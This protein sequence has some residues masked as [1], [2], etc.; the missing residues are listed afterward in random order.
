MPIFL[1]VLHL[2][3]PRSLT[4]TVRMDSSSS[5]SLP[6]SCACTQVSALSSTSFDGLDTA[7][8][9]T[10]GVNTRGFRR[11]LVAPSPLTLG[12]LAT[13]PCH[14]Q[15]KPWCLARTRNRA[16]TRRR[17]WKSTEGV[18]QCALRKRIEAKTGSQR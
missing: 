2:L 10:F 4:L 7:P 15:G 17:G 6:R 16:R 5:A 12:T 8:N 13:S 18:G 11:S 9:T 1:Q 3:R 14:A